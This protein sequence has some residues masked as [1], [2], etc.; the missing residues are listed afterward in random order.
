MPIFQ[1]VEDIVADLSKR[2]G[3]KKAICIPRDDPQ[4]IV[5]PTSLRTDLNHSTAIA[6]IRKSLPHFHKQTTEIYQLMEGSL[7]VYVDGKRYTLFGHEELVIAPGKV[8]HA[9]LI[10]GSRLDEWC[11]VKVLAS[12]PWSAEDHHLAAPQ[13]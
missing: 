3:A 12:P 8:H 11:I 2:W 4:E 7:C 13:L 10:R 5:G 1:R 9:E 6:Y